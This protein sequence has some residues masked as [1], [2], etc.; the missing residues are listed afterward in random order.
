MDDERIIALFFSRDERAISALADQCGTLSRRMAQNILGTAEDA[1]ECINDA[2]LS[3]WNTI[4]PEHPRSLSAYFMTLVRNFALTRY[5]AAHSQKR[6]AG[7]TP[8]VLH[9]LEECVSGREDVAAEVERR[10]VLAAVT[11]FLGDLPE[12]QRSLFIRR[13]WY[14]DSIAALAQAFHMSENSVKV[15]LSRIRKRLRQHLEKEG[16]I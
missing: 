7:Q 2:L 3:A 10:E 8:L 5:A 1:E 15:T 12:V 11:A 6:G 14:A 16:L 13:Y 4:P 9:E